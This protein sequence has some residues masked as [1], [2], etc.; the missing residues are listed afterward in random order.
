M[1]YPCGVAFDAARN[2]AL[3]AGMESNSLA[4]VNVSDPTDPAV[5]GGVSNMTYMDQALHVAYDDVRK[6]V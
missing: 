4:V 2:L 5:V 6:L 1:Q 3:V